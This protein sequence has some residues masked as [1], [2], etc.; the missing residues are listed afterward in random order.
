MT[1][2]G[3][4]TPVPMPN[5]AVKPSCADG[6]SPARGWE[7]RSSPGFFFSAY[8]YQPSAVRYQLSVVSHQLSAE[9]TPAVS[10]EDSGCVS[11]RRSLA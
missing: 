8:S 11:G 7:S 9:A 2:S 1:D 6:T 10:K 3:G 5:T 4:E